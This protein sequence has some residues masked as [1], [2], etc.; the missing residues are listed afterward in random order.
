MVYVRL[1]RKEMGKTICEE[2]TLRNGYCTRGEPDCIVVSSDWNVSD[3]G[4][5]VTMEDFENIFNRKLN[6]FK[7]EVEAKKTEQQKEKEKQLEEAKLWK[8][9]M[10][11]KGFI[12]QIAALWKWRKQNKGGAL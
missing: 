4:F 9:E 12:R 5:R 10:E 3:K 6:E 7:K 11:G 8:A 1:I 2:L